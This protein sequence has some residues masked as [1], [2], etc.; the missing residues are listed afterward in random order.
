[1]LAWASVRCL[2]WVSHDRSLSATLLAKSAV[3]RKLT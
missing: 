1:M 3:I 2:L